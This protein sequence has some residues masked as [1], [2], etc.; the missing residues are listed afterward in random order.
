MKFADAHFYWIGVGP[1]RRAG[2]KKVFF[3]IITYYNNIVKG[4][5]G[6]GFTLPGRAGHIVWGRSA[7]PAFG[8]I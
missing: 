5:L 7:N 3:I 1:L 6:S 8:K 4:P 2:L